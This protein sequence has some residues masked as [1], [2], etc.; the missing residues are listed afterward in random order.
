MGTNSFVQQKNR[1]A[2]RVM[3]IAKVRVFFNKERADCDPVKNGKLDKVA[4]CP[5][6]KDQSLIQYYTEDGAEVIRVCFHRY[7]PTKDERCDY[8]DKVD[9]SE[10]LPAWAKKTND[11]A[12]VA[13]NAV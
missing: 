11:A 12:N 9:A 8:T 7:D 5:Q 10:L 1:Q 4:L 6:C 3:M 13:A 2:R